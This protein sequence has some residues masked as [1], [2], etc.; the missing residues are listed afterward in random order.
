[1]TERQKSLSERRTELIAKSA[2]Q[3]E[4]LSALIENVWQ[5][6]AVSTGKNILVLA[7]HNPLASGLMAFL[8]FV[9]FRRR[10]LFSLLAVG[11]VLYKNWARWSHY[12]MPAYSWLKKAVKKK[13]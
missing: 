11:T 8:A 13:R 3:R 2:I 1:M 9:F 6:G 12:L 10:K 4:Q 5:P 7:R